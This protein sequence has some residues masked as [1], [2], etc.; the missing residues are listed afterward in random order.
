MHASPVMLVVGA[1]PQF[2]KVA[3]LAR[4]IGSEHPVFTVHTG[5][6]FDD[7]MS[8]TFLETFGLPIDCN[9]GIHGGSNPDMVGRMLPA[10]ETQIKRVAPSCVVV[11]GDTSTTLA[12]ALAARYAGVPVVHYEAGQRSFDLSMPEEVNRICTDHVSDLLLCASRWAEDRLHAEAVGGQIEFVGDVM[13]DTM[14]SQLDPALLERT[15]PPLN[16]PVLVTIHR[17]ANT[18]DGLRLRQIVEAMTD[19]PQLDFVFPVHPRTRAALNRHELFE[20]LNAAPNI[21]VEPPASYEDFLERL[22]RAQKVMTDSGGVQKEAHFVKVPCVTCRDATEWVETLQDGWNTLVGADR[23]RIQGALAARPPDPTT[24]TYPY[25]R[26]DSVDAVTESIMAFV[27][28]ER[29]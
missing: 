16:G 24:H 25:G 27:R 5:Q 28:K 11:F 17:Q 22:G 15:G 26:G 10:L 12:A 2:V 9:L 29:S 19:S 23:E 18:D 1:R 6:H 14:V 3:L 8:K 7:N 13:L 20:D 21:Q 4:R